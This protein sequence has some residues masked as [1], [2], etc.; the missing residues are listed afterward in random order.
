MF[1]QLPTWTIRTFYRTNRDRSNLKASN[2]STK[3]AENKHRKLRYVGQ[4]ISESNQLHSPL[5][6]CLSLIET[7]FARMR[8]LATAR[9]ECLSRGHCK[10]ALPKWETDSYAST[11][12]QAI[13]YWCYLWDRLWMP[14][15]ERGMCKWMLGCISSI[16]RISAS[17]YSYA[18][19]AN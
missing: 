9:G 16:H 11:L 8:Q 10:M 12:Q 18:F 17:A 15:I 4:M 5:K 6:K 2:V 19:K 3:Y 13:E 14:F 1:G 7:S